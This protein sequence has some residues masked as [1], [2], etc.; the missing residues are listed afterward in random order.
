M[1]A[2]VDTIT[3][4]F[5]N[6]K[7]RLEALFLTAPTL[8][9]AG[10]TTS[11]TELYGDLEDFIYASVIYHFAATTGGAQSETFD[12][13]T[14][15][16]M[17]ITRGYAG[18]HTA[19]SA[20]IPIGANAGSSSYTFQ[21]SIDEVAGVVNLV[22]DSATPG[23]DKLYGTNGSGVRGWY[24]QSAAIS[25]PVAGIALSTGSAWDTSITDA[26][27]DWNTAYGWGDH[28]GLY[29]DLSHTHGNVTNAGAIG[30]TINLPIITT[31]SGVLTVGSFGIT[32]NTFC[33]GDDSRLSDSRTPTSHTLLS[34]TISGET[35]GHVLAADSATTY[36]IRQLL[37]SEINN[38][39]SWTTNAGTVTSVTGGVGIDSTGGATPSITLDCNE[40]SAGGTLIATDKL[41]AVNGTT[42]NTQLISSIPLSIFND[43]LSY[44]NYTHPN[45]SGHVTS[46]ADGAQTLVVAAITG[47][48]ALTT[49]LVSTD[50]LLVSDGA[51]KRMDISVLET[52]MQ[53]ELSFGSVITIGNTGEIPYSDTGTPGTDFDYISGFAF[54]GT[55]LVTP[56]DITAAGQIISIGSSIIWDATEN[57]RISI[58]PG[59]TTLATI[60]YYDGSAFH[61]MKF[62]HNSANKGIFYDAG[63][64]RVGIL[65]DTP[66]Y[67]LD[68]NGSIRSV[69]TVIG[70]SSAECFRVGG[71]GTTSSP[72]IAWYQTTTRRSYIQHVDTGDMLRINSEYGGIEFYTGTNGSDETLKMLISSTGD[73]G[74]GA[75]TAVT[76]GYKLELFSTDNK[77]RAADWTATSDRR[78]KYEIN[79]HENTLDK[80]MLTKGM[81]STYIRHADK[82]N[83]T[84]IGYIAQDLMEVFPEL[85]G[86]SE[87]Q[88]YDISYMKTGPIAMEGVAVLKTEIDELRDRIFELEKEVHNLG[89][90]KYGNNNN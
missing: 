66:S 61:D 44:N 11:L 85:V 1:P 73:V 51:I 18:V 49:G 81:L 84:E 40:L 20:A 75:N 36:S 8:W 29:A 57:T 54:D 32:S 87:E 89:N 83:K 3:L 43:D 26:S 30:T 2:S 48:T 55:D 41:V 52:Y 16:Y 42:T 6:H 5:D 13:V 10:M 90:R 34:H 60:Y 12:P 88:M 86:G 65:D 45:H 33:E 15:N 22:N 31:T 56:G 62:G 53:A 35:I 78:L 47:Q 67:T 74:I 59:S 7:T 21:H 80:I 68:V 63:S 19:Q 27:A 58:N 14:H 79:P 4:V 50:E 38:D 82:D 64:E 71:T 37:G 77:G 72:Y 23:N 17:F 28:A 25:Y 39:L 24:D 76:A 69:G 70:Y 46:V 9:E